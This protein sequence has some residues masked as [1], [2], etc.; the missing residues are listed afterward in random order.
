MAVVV[1]AARNAKFDWSVD[2]VRA[3]T[4]ANLPAEDS[5]PQRHRIVGVTCPKPVGIVTFA[6]IVNAI[7]RVAK[8]R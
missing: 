6:D 8:S 7:L 1:P 5:L 3:V 2:F 4:L